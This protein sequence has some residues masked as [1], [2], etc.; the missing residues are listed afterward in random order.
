MPAFENS[1]AVSAADLRP[2]LCLLTDSHENSARAYTTPTFG[3][4]E[5]SRKRQ[6][7]PRRISRRDRKCHP[8]F[9]GGHFSR[10]K[11][12]LP[13]PDREYRVRTALFEARSHS[14]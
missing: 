5:A 14:G 2:R 8:Q 11:A 12:I 3:G 4:A 6:S 1:S 13:D 10:G 9:Y 7:H